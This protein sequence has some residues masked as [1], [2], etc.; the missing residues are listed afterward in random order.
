MKKPKPLD[1][2]EL[3][4]KLNPSQLDFKTTEKMKPLSGFVGQSRA[5]EALTF[6]IGIK[7]HGYN[8]YG[9]GPTEINKHS[10]VNQVLEAHAEKCP[11]PPD[12]CYIHNF[13]LPAKPIAL[14]LP[15]GMGVQ[16]QQDMKQ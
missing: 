4:L 1:Y 6:G 12:W 10:F 3:C 9:M 7:S 5:L 2:R 14:E 16:L 13:D 15:P 8:L 11:V